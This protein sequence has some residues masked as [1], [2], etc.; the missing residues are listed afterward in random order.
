VFPTYIQ[1]V[2]HL[3]CELGIVGSVKGTLKEEYKTPGDIA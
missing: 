2:F 3:Y 1:E